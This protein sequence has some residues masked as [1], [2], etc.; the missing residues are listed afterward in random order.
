MANYIGNQ[1]QRG[2]FKKLD[3]VSSLFDG[4]TTTFNLTFNSTPVQVGDTTAL[5]VSLNG[6]IQEPG[7]SYT[8]ATG[9]SQIVFSS[10]PANGASCFITQLGGIGD[11]TTPSD[12]SVTASK[13]A[14]D[15]VSDI[16]DKLDS[17]A[18][19]STYAPINNPEFTGSYVK[20]PAG[21]TASRPGTGQVG[22]IRYNTD[23]ARLEQYT[24][25][26]WAAIDTPPTIT[27][28]SYSGGLLAADPAGGE[29]ITLSGTNFQSGFSVTVGGTTAPST[30]YI[31]STQVQF[32]TPAKTAGDY[33]IKLTNSNGLV[34]TLIDGIAYNGLPA[35]TTSAGQLGNDLPPSSTISTITIVAA[36]P[37]S[38]AISYSITSGALPT[39]LSLSSGGE[40][41]GTTPATTGTTTYNFTV[42][43]TDDENQTNSRAF[44]LVVLRPLFT[45]N[46][47][48]S[49][50]FQQDESPNLER[51]ITTT[52]SEQKYTFSFWYKRPR[53]DV[54]CVVFSNKISSIGDNSLVMS[55]NTSGR[56]TV[57]NA[58]TGNT[59]YFQNLND[60]YFLDPGNWYHIVVSIDTTLTSGR[61]KVYVNGNEVSNSDQIPQNANLRISNSS[62]V[63]TIGEDPRDNVHHDGYLAEVHF[64]DGTALPATTFGESYGGV[65]LPKEVTGVTYGT[66][67]FYLPFKHDNAVG[68]FHAMTYVGTGSMLDLSTDM[69][70]DLVWIKNRNSGSNHCLFDRVRN[71]G[72]PIFSSSTSGQDT[73]FNTWS[74]FTDDGF[75]LAGQN[76]EVNTNNGNYV[77]WCW[78]MGDTTVTNNDGS[79]TS[80]VRANTAYGQS[81]VRYTGNQG[82]GTVGHGLTEA[83]DLIMIKAYDRSSNWAVWTHATP[84]SAYRL[85]ASDAAS[86]SYFTNSF[87]TAPTSTVF[88]VVDN[89]NGA[90]TNSGGNQYVAYC[91]HEVSGYS[92]FGTY[93]GNG[94]SSGP[95]INCGFKPSFLITKNISTSGNWRVNDD[96]R[97]TTNPINVGLNANE[98]AQTDFTQ[99]TAD[100]NS[101]NFQIVDTGGSNNSGDQ[102]IY[103]AF[104][105]KR[106]FAF[107]RDLSGNN[108]DFQ[109]NFLGSS[110]V[111]NDGPTE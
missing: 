6:V 52:G 82:T 68:G 61:G 10:A 85:E 62:Y 57:V 45:Y 111:V 11:T 54:S 46:V 100:F 63:H 4:S 38:G 40:I 109:P 76:G 73:L 79:I 1:I 37:D 70:P 48:Q 91:F 9:G 50:H 35:F 26:G 32:T 71:N 77:A 65:W 102:Y 14:A 81:I 18:A 97:S 53:T 104:A 8:L 78:D 67:G 51:A 27:S 75:I 58:T 33:D 7:V 89:G 69:S 92:S 87:G 83:P 13:L 3:N 49:L 23:F 59:N 36:E 19:A 21:D 39:G 47:T 80:D 103:I 95:I 22:M 93:T 66:N 20:V 90:Q 106:D 55:F 101:D 64:V 108:N 60:D 12:G 44:N 74:E 43:A 31:S 34:A 24:S 42:T 29:T 107:W 98:A 105:D 84:T 86:G 25:D 72:Y 99:N 30:T 41:T 16:N 94:S 28:A 15:V 110:E 2:E 17:T 5:I 88:S 56:F 96:V